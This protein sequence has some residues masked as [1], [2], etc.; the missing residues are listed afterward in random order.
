MILTFWAL[1]TKTMIYLRAKNWR[2]LIYF[3]LMIKNN[4]PRKILLKIKKKMNCRIYLETTIQH[5]IKIK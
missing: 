3:H 2:N 5:K 1:Q 4:K